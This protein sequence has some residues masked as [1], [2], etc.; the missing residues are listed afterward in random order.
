MKN[1]KVADNENDFRI[2]TTPSLQSRPLGQRDRASNLSDHFASGKV[3]AAIHVSPEA[4]NGGA[5][6]KV[7]DGD[8]IALDC[9]NHQLTLEVSDAELAARVAP[10][11]DL[12]AKQRGTGR[13]IFALFRTHAAHAEDGASPLL[14][15]L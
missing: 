6:A 10:A 2:E 4:V 1:F 5:I 3:S 15:H 9:D 12:S 7:L 8:F 11:P 13:D 14:G